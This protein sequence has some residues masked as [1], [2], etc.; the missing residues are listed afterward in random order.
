M[1]IFSCFLLALIT[2]AVHSQELNKNVHIIPEPVSIQYGLGH[3]HVDERVSISYNSESARVSAQLFADFVEQQIGR[4][5]A[6][7]TEGRRPALI[8]FKSSNASKK[9]GYEL[10]VTAKD[11]EIIGDEAG[12]FYAVQTLLQL[13]ENTEGLYIPA[14][15]IEDYPRFPHRGMMID[16]GRFF[17]PMDY[18]KR[19]IDVMALYKLNRFHFHLTE[20]AGWRIEIKALPRL[21]EIGSSRGG[22]QIAHHPL[23]HIESPHQGYYTQDELRELV[24]YAT[25]RHITIVPEIDMPGHMMAAIAAYPYLSC[26]GKQLQVPEHWGIKEHILCAGKDTVYAFVEQVLT[27]VM[28]IFPSEYIHIGGDEAPKKQ[29]K[30]CPICQQKIKDEGLGDEEGLQSYFIRR[31]ERFVNSKGRNIIGWDEILEGGLAPNATVMSWRGEEGGIAAAKQGNQ[32]IMTPLQFLYLDY[33]ESHE[34]EPIGMGYELNMRR[35][36]E[37][38]PVPEQLSAAEQ[39][40]IIGLQGNLW[41]EFIHNENKMDYRAWPRG[42]AVA[43]TGWSPKHKRDFLHFRK[44]LA[45]HLGRHVVQHTHFRIPEPWD[46]SYVQKLSDNRYKLILVPSVEGA[47]LFYTF[48]HHHHPSIVYQDGVLLSGES[49]EKNVIRCRI[50]LPNGRDVIYTKNI[51]DLPVV[52]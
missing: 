42:L 32:V 6:V 3:F 26:T 9:E 20:D 21:T 13:M 5:L 7:A 10:K 41:S 47:K 23:D 1:R 33:A 39:T 50:V 27:E 43:E 35:V 30:A 44:R 2:F 18:I 25:E 49:R 45:R 34:W 31:V 16:V 28:D 36:Y 46:L 19:F 40:K 8:R 4:K 37:Y 12:L 17:Y 22:T 48:E 52:D 11:I 51:A 14:V 38:D 15:I 29:W 24:A